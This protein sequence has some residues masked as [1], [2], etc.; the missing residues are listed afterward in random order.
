MK[1]NLSREALLE[2]LQKVVGAIERKQTMP[3]LANVLIHSSQNKLSIT[4]T[5]LEIELIANRD[6]DVAQDGILTLPGQKL[7]E[8]CKNLP[9]AASITI[10][11]ASAD[12]V[13]IH[14]GRSRF[15]LSSLPAEQFPVLNNMQVL[16]SFSIKQSELRKV[17]EKTEFAMAQQ[18]VRFYLNGLMLELSDTTIRTVATDGHRLAL[19]QIDTGVNLGEKRQILIPSKGVRELMR[20]LNDSD[21]IAMISIDNKQICVD[22]GKLRFTCKL[23]DSTFPDYQRV[24]PIACD[25]KISLDKAELK[26]ALVR[27]SI[28]SN[29]KFKGVRLK[30]SHNVLSMQTNNPEQEEAEEQIV[31]DY[32]GESMEISFNI[33]YILDV[34]GAIDSDQIELE[35]KDSA[36]SCRVQQQNPQCSYVIMPMRI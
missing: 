35:L 14:S 13:N 2:P 7:L 30:I 33:K 10:E 34:I 21:E 36:S 8:I 5:D 29:E 17:I 23:I 6:L 27:T 28:L 15:K 26:Q 4:A 3:I 25:K 16:S 22:M 20:M 32:T 31:I 1:L 11:Q 24:M 19:A 18:D 12:K 9:D